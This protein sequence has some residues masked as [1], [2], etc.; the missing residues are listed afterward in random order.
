MTPFDSGFW[1]G[2][3]PLTQMGK[4]DKRNKLESFPF[5]AT[6]PGSITEHKMNRDRTL[7]FFLGSK[8]WILG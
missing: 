5:H 7:L 6:D 8:I 4:Q 1:E 3:M 2:G